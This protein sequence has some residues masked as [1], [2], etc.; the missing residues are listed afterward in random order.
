VTEF[1]DVEQCMRGTSEGHGPSTYRQTTNVHE[2]GATEPRPLPCRGTEWRIVSERVP[3]CGWRSPTVVGRREGRRV[4][5]VVD[6]RTGEWCG[7]MWATTGKQY[8][9]RGVNRVRGCGA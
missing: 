2:S 3:W 8:W 7:S 9:R 5:G 4:R 1:C 6:V